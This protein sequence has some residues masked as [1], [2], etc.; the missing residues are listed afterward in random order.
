MEAGGR[1]RL[2]TFT[3][4]IQNT[5]GR[6]WTLTFHQAMSNQ[7]QGVYLIPLWDLSPPHKAGLKYGFRKFLL[8]Y[9]ELNFTSPNGLSFLGMSNSGTL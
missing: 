4:A 9:T 8:N 2:P 6:F 7:G 1:L 3:K 5:D